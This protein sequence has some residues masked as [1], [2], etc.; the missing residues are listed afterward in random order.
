[1]NQAQELQPMKS[2]EK[3]STSTATM[4]R[5]QKGPNTAQTFVAGQSEADKLAAARDIA[6]ILQQEKVKKATPQMEWQLSEA[7]QQK[8][9]VVKT[10]KIMGKVAR[11]AVILT[12]NVVDPV[13]VVKRLKAQST[14]TRS[15]LEE[16]VALYIEQHNGEEPKSIDDLPK[17]TRELKK[18]GRSE[19]NRLFNAA[20]NERNNP[21]S[22]GFISLG[23][24]AEQGNTAAAELGQRLNN[25]V[26]TGAINNLRGLPLEQ[27]RQFL[28]ANRGEIQNH[29]IGIFTDLEVNGT[30]GLSQLREE[31][32]NHGI[33]IRHFTRTVLHTAERVANDESNID[34]VLG[35]V[36][37]TR[38]SNTYAHKL[39]EE[40]YHGKLRGIAVAKD[41]VEAAATWGKSAVALGTSAVALGGLVGISTTAGVPLA[42]AGGAAMGANVAVR[43][44]RSM[45]NTREDIG[46]A[47]LQRGRGQTAQRNESGVLGKVAGFLGKA[48]RTHQQEVLMTKGEGQT[49][50]R[51]MIGLDEFYGNVSLQ[52]AVG[53]GSLV[54]NTPGDFVR[55]DRE[56]GRLSREELYALAGRAIDLHEAAPVLSRI[57]E[58]KAINALTLRYAST[59]RKFIAGDNALERL[60]TRVE[61]EATLMD[62]LHISQ[63]QL[64]AAVAEFTQAWTQAKMQDLAADR[65]MNILH[66]VK[67]AGV[68]GLVGAGAV[69]AGI[70]LMEHIDFGVLGRD[71][72][73]TV[74]DVIHNPLWIHPP[75]A[76]AL[77]GGPQ[78]H[79]ELFHQ[80]AGP[81]IPADMQVVPDSQFHDNL[82]F[83]LERKGLDGGIARKWYVQIDTKTNEAIVYDDPGF[84]HKFAYWGTGKP[85]E[86]T[87]FVDPAKIHDPNYLIQQAATLRTELGATTPDGT[88]YFSSGTPEVSF[89]I[90]DPNWLVTT[91]SQGHTVLEQFSNAHHTGQPLKIFYVRSDTGN[92]DQMDIYKNVHDYNNQTNSVANFAVDPTKN[93]AVEANQVWSQLEVSNPQYAN[94]TPLLPDQHPFVRPDM[95]QINASGYAHGEDPNLLQ[96]LLH[97]V[98]PGEILAIEDTLPNG[99]HLVFIVNQKTG[100]LTLMRDGTIISYGDHGLTQLDRHLVYQAVRSGNLRYV[101]LDEHTGKM[102]LL[103]G[104]VHYGGGAP[105]EYATLH[106]AMIN[107]N[108]TDN[109]EHGTLKDV[110]D[111]T[112]TFNSPTAKIDPAVDGFQQEWRLD[113][114]SS[115]DLSG[116]TFWLAESADAMHPGLTL[117]E[118]GKPVSGM[119]D[120]EYIQNPNFNNGQP[121][122]IIGDEHNIGHIISEESNGTL[123]LDL[124]KI[125]QA[126]SNIHENIIIT[127]GNAQ[128]EYFL[129]NMDNGSYD[130]VD[131][132]GNVVATGTLNGNNLQLTATGTDN[133]SGTHTFDI[134]QSGS[135]DLSQL[136]QQG[137]D[138]TVPWYEAG[139][140]VNPIYTA[141][142]V[143]DPILAGRLAGLEGVGEAVLAGGLVYGGYRLGRAG[144]HRARAGAGNPNGQPNLPPP[145]QPTQLEAAIRGYGLVPGSIPFTR[146]NNAIQSV[147][148]NLSDD[149]IEAILLRHVGDPDGAIQELQGGQNGGTGIGSHPILNPGTQLTPDPTHNTRTIL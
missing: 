120:L 93:I 74:S 46:R 103:T 73:S 127:N 140:Y 139:G 18:Q 71:M 115:K 148:G 48:S 79:A 7:D 111:V 53:N 98:P 34:F 105:A 132:N 4:E 21:L 54:L 144:I 119:N 1:M 92:P 91:D 77:G 80:N 61:L 124:D 95:M 116:H 78:V 60:H 94:S 135:I 51:H 114:H 117:F 75:A 22:E 104:S 36:R 130:V 76:H 17:L 101:A 142:H 106:T 42:I 28:A 24:L 11:N 30:S 87:F 52:E 8:N 13:V 19:Y 138:A 81:S 100:D 72:Q 62:S 88:A 90:S 31:M 37:T 65:R 38:E 47:E 67:R 44:A 84:Q 107:Q 59:N 108:I 25:E 146:L 12:R 125:P 23:V 110:H 102:T 112:V 3:R 137:Q 55:A 32:V 122:I 99:R 45:A 15:R 85:Q 69:G 56:L 66:G 35:Y 5:P 128:G 126:D 121:A 2:A 57:A 83:I 82:H 27:R 64:D 41:V 86:V 129:V 134:S 145:A 147:Q 70:R 26:I 10:F 143:P 113:I 149:E 29:I 123:R 97:N 40:I 43:V 118:D 20:E 89:A 96:N 39:H 49:H 50:M 58:D 63:V 33:D 136:Q 14:T 131:S 68:S 6:Y 9:N 133:I 109:L 141:T 16:Q